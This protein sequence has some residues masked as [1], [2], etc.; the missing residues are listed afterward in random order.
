MKKNS[1]IRLWGK[2]PNSRV[3]EGLEKIA[4]GSLKNF[5]L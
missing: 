2:I 4:W 3:S 1:Q 5:H